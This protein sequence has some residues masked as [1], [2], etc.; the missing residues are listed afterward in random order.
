M[1]LES[2]TLPHDRFDLAAFVA[3][4]AASPAWDDTE[5]AR[6]CLTYFEEWRAVPMP[7]HDAVDAVELLEAGLKVH[8][9]MHACPA[10]EMF[11]AIGGEEF[12]SDDLDVGLGG[13]YGWVVELHADRIELHPALYDECSG[14]FPRM[15]AESSCSIVERPMIE[16]VRRFMLA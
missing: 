3:E 16:F 7:N 13:S 11:L 9:P 8:F 6:Y 1:K 12:D 2:I 5:H 15:R 4:Y 10:D 14:P